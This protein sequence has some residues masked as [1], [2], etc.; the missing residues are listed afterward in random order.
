MSKLF[1]VLESL[2][3][4]NIF[5]FSVESKTFSRLTIVGRKRLGT[6]L[7]ATAFASELLSPP[8]YFKMTKLVFKLHR[9]PFSTK[10]SYSFHFKMTITFTN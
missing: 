1:K 10:K 9:R 2:Q 5:F 7:T 6:S 8:Y 4:L 3:Y